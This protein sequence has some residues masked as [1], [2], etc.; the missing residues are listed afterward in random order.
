MVMIPT[1]DGGSFSMD[2]YLNDNL[3]TAKRVIKKDWDFLILV[4][5][6]E[7]SGK[8]VL[9]M[10]T[11]KMLDPTFNLTRVTFTSQ[12]FKKAILKAEKYQAV[13]YDEAYTGLNSKGAMGIINRALVEMLAEARQRNLFIIVIMPTF[14]DLVRYVAIWRSVCLLH[15]YTGDDFE[16]GYF[17]FYNEEKKKN[18]YIL[19]KKFYNY[20]TPENYARPNFTGRFSNTYIVPEQE[21]RQ[22]KLTNLKNKEQKGEEE[23][24][25]PLFHKKMFSLLQE[26]KNEK[27]TH[28]IKMEILGLPYGTYYHQLKNYVSENELNDTEDSL[29]SDSLGI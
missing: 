26:C 3:L 16:R 19:G 24:N 21:Y 10:Q 27:L 13:L 11:A 17:A 23:E 1:P 29:E 12:Q 20:K 8:S 2:G 7:G 6:R 15:V 9:G 25:T 5:G 22:L 14:F 18:L 28:S 4:D